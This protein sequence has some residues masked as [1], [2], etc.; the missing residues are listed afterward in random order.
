MK[1]CICF[2]VSS[3]QRQTIYDLLPNKK[4]I[5]IDESDTKTPLETLMDVERWSHLWL[6]DNQIVP[7]SNIVLVE[8][9]LMEMIDGVPDLQYEE[10]IEVIKQLINHEQL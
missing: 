10:F 5:A 9:N 1:D 7:T 3:T 4:I 2:N 8:P 6:R